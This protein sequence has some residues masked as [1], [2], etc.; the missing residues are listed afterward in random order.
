MFDATLLESYEQTSQEFRL[1]SPLGER[2]DFIVGAFW[3]TSDHEYADS[4]RIP[5]N[6]ILV[7]AVN[8]RS[9]GAGTLIRATEANRVATV[10]GDVL[11][12]FGQ[13]SWHISP[14]WT[15]QLG[16]RYT[17]EEKDG[18]LVAVDLRQWRRGAAGPAGGVACGLGE[19]LRHHLD[20]S[21]RARADRGR[22]H[23]AAR[24]AARER[25]A[26]GEEVL[27]RREAAVERE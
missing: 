4:I 3:Q 24:L 8:A 12:A 1:T 27:A 7:P 15:L 6:S 25:L 23:L 13:F 20:E 11:A 21:R 10:D 9:P 18:F 14:D 26:R 22:A 5:A 19:P 16:G 2:Y 17:R